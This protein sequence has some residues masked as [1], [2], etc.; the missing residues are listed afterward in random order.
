MIL[1]KGEVC[2][3]RGDPHTNLKKKGAKD[4]GKGDI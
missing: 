4:R 1:L 2:C 3:G